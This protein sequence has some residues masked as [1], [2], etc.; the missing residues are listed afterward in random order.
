MN[1]DPELQSADGADDAHLVVSRQ[2]RA[3]A[4]RQNPWRVYFEPILRV[5]DPMVRCRE[6][7]RD[8]RRGIA[9]TLGSRRGAVGDNASAPI[10]GQLPALPTRILIVDDD[11]LI[12][13]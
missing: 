7:A 3:E 2:P 8:P 13:Q 5:G 6:A 4:G 10:L 1:A 12:R 11:P 9:A